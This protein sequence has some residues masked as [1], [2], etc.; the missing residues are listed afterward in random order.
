MVKEVVF[1]SGGNLSYRVMFLSKRKLL[2]YIEVCIFKNIL[3]NYGRK[4]IKSI[5][6]VFI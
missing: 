2:I 4:V 5:E 6:L 3:K 1:L